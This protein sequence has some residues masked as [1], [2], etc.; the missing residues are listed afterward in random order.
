MAKILLVEDDTS[1]S[2]LYKTSLEVDNNEVIVSADGQD[3]LAKL[4]SEKYDLAILDIVLPNTSGLDILKKIRETESIKSMKV[5]MLTNYGQQENVKEAYD[6]GADD[7]FLK[8]RV[9]PTEATEKI[10]ALLGG[11]A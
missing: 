5:I 11:L 2:Q 8:Y 9:T 7:V 6:A 3:G 10:R 4:T 1:L